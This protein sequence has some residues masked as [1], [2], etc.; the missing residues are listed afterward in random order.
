MYCNYSE[1]KQLT[2]SEYAEKLLAHAVR[3]M[4]HNAS[5]SYQAFAGF[6]ERYVSSKAS[7]SLVECREAMTIVAAEYG[8][9]IMVL[10]GLDECPEESREVLFDEFE[11]LEPKV[12]FLITSRYQ[13]PDLFEPQVDTVYNIRALDSDIASY[14]KKRTRNFKKFMARIGDDKEL[15][16]KILNRIVERANGM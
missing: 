4:A 14:V 12:R 9:I 3:Q 1:A 10:D 7:P 2:A 13:F 5:T 16:E 8:E 15:Q 11:N 6:R